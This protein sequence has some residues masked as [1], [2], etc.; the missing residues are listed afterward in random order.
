VVDRYF[1]QKRNRESMDHLLLP[2]EAACAGL[3][4][5]RFFYSILI[6]GQGFFFFLPPLIWLNKI[7]LRAAFFAWSAALGKIFIMDNLTN[8]K[9]LW[10]IGTLCI[11]GTGNPWA[12][13]FSHV[14]QLVPYGMFIYIWGNSTNS[15]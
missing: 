10:S 15:P 12:I 3:L 9:S 4:D 13:F 11:T 6:C 8:G 1:I 5:V 2:C 7:P 14:R